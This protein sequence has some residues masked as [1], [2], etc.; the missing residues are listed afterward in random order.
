VYNQVH[1]DLVTHDA[2]GISAR[3]VELARALEALAGRWP[4]A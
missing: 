2:K 4:R 1:V 3:D